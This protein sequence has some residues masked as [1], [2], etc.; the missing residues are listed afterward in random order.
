MAIEGSVGCG[1][2]KLDMECSQDGVRREGAA[3]EVEFV[4]LSAVI[5]NQN[6]SA[7][8]P[9]AQRSE[10]SQPVR[11][12]K[13]TATNVLSTAADVP[14]WVDEDK[15][16][17]M[18]FLEMA[19]MDALKR[20]AT[21]PNP[22]FPCALIAGDVAI[23]HLLHRL[24]LLKS[25]KVKVVFIDTF[26]LFP[27]TLEFLKSV[28]ALFEFK[29]VE[30]HADG[31]A[32]K[33]DYKKEHGSDLFLVDIEKYDQICKTLETGCMI[34]GRRRDHGAER[35]HLEAFE[36][37]LKK[38]EIPAHP[39]HDQGFPS[40]GDV[41]STIPVPKEKWFEYAGERSGRFQG[42]TNPDGSTKTDARDD[43]VVS[44]EEDEHKTGGV[45]RMKKKDK[46]RRQAAVDHKD[47]RIRPTNNQL[48]YKVIFKWEHYDHPLLDQQS[49]PVETDPCASVTTAFLQVL[50]TLQDAEAMRRQRTNRSILQG[51][52]AMQRQRT[53]RS[54]LQVK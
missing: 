7:R 54:I 49:L 1:G 35:A 12:L 3:T 38:Y 23:L 28:E 47:G 30:F 52:E 24:D 27:E 37:Y 13:S 10:T 36:E 39:L 34:N 45:K 22:V 51:A 5:S 21:L 32:T 43:S 20:A 29:A 19:S 40:I 33:E 42:L 16:S 18:N 46:D 14:A 6:R 11:P 26:H 44:D 2:T 25:G 53:N 15:A 8:S 17:R 41:H 31:F 50:K 4:Y 9:D 48:L